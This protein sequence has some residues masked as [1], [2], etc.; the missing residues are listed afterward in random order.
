MENR[1]VTLMDEKAVLRDAERCAKELV[2][3]ASNS[4][5]EKLLNAPWGEKRPYWRS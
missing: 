5:T 3:G 2:A 4:D 1:A